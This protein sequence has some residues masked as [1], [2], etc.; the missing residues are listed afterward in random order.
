LEHC[1]STDRDGLY[2]QPL[3]L[4]DGAAGESLNLV[5]R[6]LLTGREQTLTFSR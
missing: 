5:V 3:K 4:P 2:N 6:S 1:V